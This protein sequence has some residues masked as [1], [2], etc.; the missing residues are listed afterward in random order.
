[1]RRSL[2]A[3]SRP[4]PA[5]RT[6]LFFATS[7]QI[8]RQVLHRL[9][10]SRWLVSK[11][12]LWLRPDAA[13][14]ARE[15]ALVYH[16]LNQINLADESRSGG[17]GL[18]LSLAA[19]N[20]AESAGDLLEPEQIADIYVAAAFRITFALP[21]WLHWLNRLYLSLAR[22][23]CARSACHTHWLL[24]PDGHRFFVSGRLVALI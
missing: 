12:G 2:H 20:M 4:L 11:A 16:R 14:S 18:M 8:V 7:W 19:V 23:A 15:L 5:S 24:T 3:L 21:P 9:W 6:E 10:F 17:G 22:Q 1:M 13:H